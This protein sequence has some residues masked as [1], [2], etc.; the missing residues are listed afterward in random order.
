[1]SDPEEDRD[2]EDSDNIEEE[3]LGKLEEPSHSHILW[4]MYTFVLYSAGLRSQ[5]CWK[6]VYVNFRVCKTHPF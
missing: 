3:G 5:S 1:M 4:S 6:Y 2:S